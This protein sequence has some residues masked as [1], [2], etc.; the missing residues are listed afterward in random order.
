MTGP[1]PMDLDAEL[2]QMLEKESERAR[3]RREGRVKAV[4]SRRRTTA[5]MQEL[6]AVAAER[7]GALPAI[8]R[9]HPWWCGGMYVCDD[10]WLD[11]ITMDRDPDAEARRMHSRVIGIVKIHCFEWE[12]GFGDPWMNI[13]DL[14]RGQDALGAA[15]DDLKAAGKLLAKIATTEWRDVE[16]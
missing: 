14:P 16:V 2:V 10:W 7:I 11:P 12:S 3:R 6:R 1:E 15:A 5:R 8:G 9:G 4:E 13:G